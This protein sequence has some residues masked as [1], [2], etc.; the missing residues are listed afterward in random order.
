MDVKVNLTTNGLYKC[1]NKTA[2]GNVA[3][4]NMSKYTA[5]KVMRNHIHQD[6]KMDYM[7]EDPCALWTSFKNRYEH[8]KATLLLEATH[9]WNHLCLQDFKT[10][11]EFNHAV[12]KRFFLTKPELRVG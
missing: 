9:E 6:L 10:I 4:S 3:P 5:L 2:E 12:H 1:I 11:D 7:Y 8:H